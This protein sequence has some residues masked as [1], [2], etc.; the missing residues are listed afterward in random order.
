MPGGWQGTA[1]SRDLAWQDPRE[2]S[3]SHTELAG[4]GTDPWMEN[5]WPHLALELNPP[6]VSVTRLRRR[7]PAARNTK[8]VFINHSACA[9]AA[10]AEVQSP[11]GEI[12]HPVA[13]PKESG[14]NQECHGKEE[15]LQGHSGSVPGGW[16]QGPVRFAK[17]GQEEGDGTRQKQTKTFMVATQDD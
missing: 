16:E 10:S 5:H 15:R 8:C 3:R 12:F 11:G 17:S 13:F 9:Q 14:K 1:R 2:H 7:T 4:S 6:P